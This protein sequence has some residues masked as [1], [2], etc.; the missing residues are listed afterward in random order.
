MLDINK[1]QD[2]ALKAST[3][4]DT[5]SFEFLQNSL[6]ELKSSSNPKFRFLALKIERKSKLQ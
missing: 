5:K 1:I 4:N 2:L 3:L 6:T